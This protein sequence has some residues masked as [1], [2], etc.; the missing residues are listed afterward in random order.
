[1]S[2]DPENNAQYKFVCAK[3]VD[4]TGAVLRAKTPHFIEFIL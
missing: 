2:L 1:M 3:L 4:M